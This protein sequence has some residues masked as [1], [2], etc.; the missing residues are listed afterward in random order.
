MPRRTGVCPLLSLLSSTRFL[1]LDVVEFVMGITLS[2]SYE[3]RSA[4]PAHEARVCGKLNT[5]KEDL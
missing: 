3:K 4:Q 1:L 5:I 2:L